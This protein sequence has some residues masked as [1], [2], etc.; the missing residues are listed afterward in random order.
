MKKIALK[1]FI[2]GAL[3]GAY[4]SAH[5]Y[6]ACRPGC[7]LVVKPIVQCICNIH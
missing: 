1:L 5:A 2:L 4:Y 6:P 7:V 3:C